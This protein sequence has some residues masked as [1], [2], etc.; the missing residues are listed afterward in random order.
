M[1]LWSQVLIGVWVLLSPWLL[2]VSGISILMWS[3]LAAGLALILMG[4][5]RIF[6]G[7]AVRSE[8]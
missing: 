3:N 5:W 7:S 6:D 2:G 1:A 4:V 8:K